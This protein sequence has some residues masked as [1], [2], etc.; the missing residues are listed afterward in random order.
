MNTRIGSIPT[1]W[2]FA[3]CVLL[4]PA[5]IAA[6]LEASLDRT[7][8][9]EGETV[10]LRLLAS[11]PSMGE[12]NITPLEQDFEILDRSQS[13]RV[14]IINGRTSSWREW[15]YILA[16]RRT[17]QLAVPALTLGN[18]FSN[19]ITLDVMPAEQSQ[20]LG[21]ARP[22]VLEVETS[23]TQPYVQS[24]VGYTVRILH[25]IPLRKAAL[26]DPVAANA[27]VQR[28]GDDRHY[29][30]NRNG[31]RY[32]VVER[33]YAIFPQR[34]G[35]LEIEGPAFKAQMPQPK[36]SNTDSRTELRARNKDGIFAWSR[37]TR[38]HG[39][40]VKLDVLPQPK[41]TARPWLPAD[42][43]SL[44]ETWTPDPPRF[45]VGEPVT[46]IMTIDAEGVTGAQ[47]PDLT[48]E[49]AP[50]MTIYPDKSQAQ[51][52]AEGNTLLARKVF[53]AAYVPAQ[54]G[55]HQLP[56]VRLA[57]W[58]NA[59]GE[60]KFAR[61]PGRAIEVLPGAV[62]NTGGSDN[63]RMPTAAPELGR[64]ANEMELPGFD[65]LPPD[66]AR[67]ISWSL[68]LWPSLAGLFA[69]AW[70]FST[71]LWWRAKRGVVPSPKPPTDAPKQSD[72]K[73]ALRRLERACRHN[74]APAARQALIDWANA[75]WPDESPRRLGDI[76]VHLSP[77][78]ANEL[79][80]LDRALYAPGTSAWEGDKAWQT[81]APAV[82]AL[83]KKEQTRSTPLPPLYPGPGK[84]P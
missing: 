31:Q 25:S 34:S 57:W 49:S 10:L 70:L 29:E 51:T 61:I 16:P 84:E 3:L 66:R 9:I 44:G 4:A 64:G 77:D 22:V 78:A 46:R 60:Q 20:A 55:K 18:Q 5:A 1:A 2:L 23:T 14:Q 54:A 6:G 27:V 39:R 30:T 24:R 19:S 17:G 26:D 15:K 58:D 69:F 37:L 75:H 32:Q 12:P 8:I 41:G 62:G 48:F 59:A 53:K 7:R 35:P 36:P 40:K 80:E 72:P 28:V 76:S 13:S 74:D 43:L 71:V 73:R 83:A 38:L 52:W 33:H 65:T 82:R 81:L 56:E 47:L 50:G 63:A 42:S 45:Q 68:P 21:L 79:Q 11:G 67:D